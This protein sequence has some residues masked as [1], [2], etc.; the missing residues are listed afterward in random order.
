LSQFAEDAIRC[1][2]L[3]VDMEIAMEDSRYRM[4]AI[5]TE[6][7]RCKNLFMTW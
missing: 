5:K 1:K 4:V 7:P 6:D 3:A 2:S